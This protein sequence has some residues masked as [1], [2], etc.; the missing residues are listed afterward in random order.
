[1]QRVIIRVAPADEPTGGWKVL[2][3]SVDLDTDTETDVLAGYPMSAVDVGGR[4]F[5]ITPPERVPAA[6]QPHAALCAGNPHAVEE[7]LDRLAARSTET[8]DVAR[9]GRWLFECLLAPAWPAI[10]QLEEVVRDRSVELA[11]S[12]DLDSD[13]HQLIWESM[14]DGEATL[15]GHPRLLVAISRLVPARDRPVATITGIPKVLF[16]AGSRLTDPVIRPGAMYMGLLRAL[17][18]NGQCQAHAVQ[19]ASI[20]DIAQACASFRPDVVHLV[21]HGVLL[22]DGRTALML[23]DEAGGQREA[24][25]TALISALSGAALPTAVVLSAC[26][27]ATPT[28]ASSL[29]AQLVAAGVPVVS[30]MAGEVSEPACRLYTRRLAQAVQE[31]QPV[32][33]ASAEG[34][35]AALL[36]SP[37]PSTEID[38]ALP[39]VF[40]AETLD[41]RQK[42]VDG[43]QARR[44]LGLADRLDL[45]R[46]PVFIGREDAV[47]TADRLV[48]PGHGV[49]AL[50]VLAPASTARLG[51]TRLLREIGWR[52]LRGGHVPLMLGPYPH[53]GAPLVARQLVTAVLQQAVL[54]A[55]RMDLPPRVPLTVRAEDAAAEQLAQELPGLIGPIARLRI[56][57]RL[58]AFGGRPGDFDPHTARDLLATDLGVLAELAATWGPPFGLSSQIVLLCDDVHAWSRPAPPAANEP[59]SALDGLLWMIGRDGIGSATRPVPVVLTGS[60]TVG[61]GQTLADWSRGAQP[62]LRVHRLEELG[63]LEALLGYQWVLLHPWT[64]KPADELPLFGRVYTSSPSMVPRWEGGLQRVPLSPTSVDSILYMIADALSAAGVGRQDDDEAAW[65]RYA[66][67]SP[68]GRT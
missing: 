55:E 31:G 35:R 59:T 66:E 3:R 41:P 67:G 11:L 2:V 38:W 17:D 16:A 40:L 7:L 26:S 1:M 47:A 23:R 37:Q 49:G 58:A 62:W 28:D 52:V 5:P 30:A 44:L 61:A 65:R 42:L 50:A 4:L 32:V 9:Y 15:A 51:G 6:T 39:A 18:A 21:A 68:G 14:H 60:V 12:W 56:R 53:G 25:A 54:V 43:T 33:K 46:E 22:A 36:S 64:T 13:L 24:D 48:E 29:A 8:G 19:A 34:R 45:R 20:E 10:T 63:S 57:E 27:T